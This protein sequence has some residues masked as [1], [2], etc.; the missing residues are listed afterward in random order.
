MGS[1]A[2]APTEC[3]ERETLP[4]RGLVLP[5]PRPYDVLGGR[6]HSGE[7]ELAGGGDICAAGVANAADSVVAEAA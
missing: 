1:E 6:R 2:A 5:G 7:S 4:L 3:N